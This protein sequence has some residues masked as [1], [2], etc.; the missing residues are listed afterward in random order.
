[1]DGFKGHKKSIETI[2]QLLKEFNIT[3]FFIPP[4]SSDQVQPLDHVGF[5]V[6]KLVILII[7]LIIFNS[8]NLYDLESLNFIF[9]IFLTVDLDAHLLILSIIKN[10]ISSMVG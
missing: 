6:Q 3:I 8:F 7:I 1:M 10:V 9:N 2:D 4:Q 5:N